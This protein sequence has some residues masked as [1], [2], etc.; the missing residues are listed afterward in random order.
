[1]EA[2]HPA[3]LVGREFVRQYYTL[4]NRAPQYLHRF[5]SNNSTFIHGGLGN[6]DRDIIPAIGQKEIHQKIQQ[7]KFCDCHT[8][9]SQV[10]SQ[11]TLGD[12]VVVQV[13]GEFSNAGNPMRR[14]TQTFVLA[15]QAPKTYY[16]HND[17][18]RYQDGFPHD[19][20]D[21]I[22]G[23]A[24]IS[25][26]TECEADEGRSENEDDDQVIHQTPNVPDQGHPGH[27]TAQQPPVHGNQQQMYYA[28]PSQQVPMPLVINGT[29]HEESPLINQQ[30]TQQPQTPQQQYIEPVTQE[31][32]SQE[33]DSTVEQPQQSQQTQ[34]QQASAVT[35]TVD[36]DVN[37]PSEESQ[38]PQSAT[39]TFQQQQQSS[40]EPENDSLNASVNANSNKPKSY[41]RTVRSNAIGGSSQVPKSSISPPPMSNMRNDD[42]PMDIWNAGSTNLSSN[43]MS[44]SQQHRMSNNQTS[45]QPQQQQQAQSQQQQQQQSQHQQRDQ[46]RDQQ[47]HQQQRPPRIGPSQKDNRGR[48][49]WPDNHQLFVGNVSHQAT[50]SEL[51]TIF[52]KFGRVADLRIFSKSNDR[53]KGQQGQ[54]NPMRVPHYG[55]VTFEDATSVA[56]VLA[57]HANKPI[58]YPDEAGQKLNIEEKKNKPRTMGDNNMRSNQNDGNMRSSMGGQPQQQQ[59]GPGGLIVMRGGQ[60]SRGGRGFSRGDGGRGGMRQPSGN[61]GNPGYQHRR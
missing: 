43:V 28:P 40:I 60:H 58:C 42:R 15:A 11:T 31:Q 51:R 3:Q 59:R 37:T 57:A 54:N 53:G 48:R 47:Q 16:V 41:A 12:G 2:P 21:D 18:F 44:A 20:G 19:E 34:S 32:F 4:L 7:L 46:Q 30:L 22:E 49:D 29:V 33:Q 5:Y 17:I 23:D 27:I 6:K 25:E 52:E 36:D 50:D 1:M 45:Q 10:D 8:R 14:F 39:E 55:F 38:E 24:N 26:V 56:K 13:T 61:M 35:S 9:I